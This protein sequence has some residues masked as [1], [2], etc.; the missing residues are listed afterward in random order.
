V[1]VARFVLIFAA[2]L[3]PVLAQHQPNVGIFMQFDASPGAASIVTAMESEV[4]RLFEPSGLALTWHLTGDQRTSEGYSRLAVVRFKGRC[5]AELAALN[6]SGVFSGGGIHTLGSTQVSDGRVLPYTEV[7]CDEVRKAL[8]FLGPGAGIAE[9][10]LALG[11]ALGRVLAHELYHILANAK[12]HASH[13]LAH[14]VEPLDDL[15][16]PKSEGFLDTDWK[17]ISQNLAAH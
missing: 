13:G 14:A 5:S 7:R 16:S 3:S 12:T 4:D 6:Q 11:R 10:Q 17:A 2:T 15:V 8:A 1:N 9:R